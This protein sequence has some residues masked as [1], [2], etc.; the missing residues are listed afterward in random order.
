MRGKLVQI[1]VEGLRADPAAAYSDV[2]A[3]PV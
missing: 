3:S 1:P 2:A